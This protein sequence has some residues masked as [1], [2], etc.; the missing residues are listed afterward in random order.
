MANTNLC[1]MNTILITN[2][3][4]IAKHAQSSGVKIIMIDLETIGKKERQNN[5]DTFISDHKLSDL[6]G[7][8]EC[9]KDSRMLVRIN[10]INKNSKKEIDSILKY[11]PDYIMLPMFKKV[12]EVKFF[13]KCINGRSRS[14]LLFE[15][16][17]SL[18]NVDDILSCKG[19][20]LAYIGLNDL[21]LELKMDFLF[22][23]LSGGIVD[24]FSKKF[25]KNKI[26][27]GFGGISRIDTGI[28]DSKLILSE[29]VRVGSQFVIL[30]RSF[31]DKSKSLSD[32]KNKLN[33]KLEIN[34]I[35][36]L[37]K[38]YCN[39]DFSLLD[40]NKLKLVSKVNKIIA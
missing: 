1:L 9:L 17:G 37:Y 25:K 18:C 24:Y 35:K 28:L 21:S 34:K 27:F 2:K 29:H 4:E 3:V 14:V 26:K 8:R 32:I 23:V 30:S 13:L 11:R 5:V 10:P 15:T 40:E 39:S 33:L 20:D 22:E 12:D 38:I 36:D 19:I 16:I 7:I 31:H 6:K